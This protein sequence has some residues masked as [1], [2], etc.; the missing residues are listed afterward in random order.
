ME[1]P[2]SFATECPKC[3][4]VVSC[5]EIAS[6]RQYDPD[7]GPPERYVFS[8]CPK[9]GSPFLTMQLDF[10]QGYDDHYRIFPSNDKS[11][12]FGIPKLIR[13]SFDEALSCFKVKAYTAC[14]I[15]CRKTL[16]GI[17]HEHGVKS[18][19]LAKSLKEMKD[20]GI[21]ESRLFEWAEALRH[22]GNEAAHGVQT[23]PLKQDTQDILDFSYALIEYVFTFRDK[24][25]KF[26]ERRKKEPN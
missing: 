10:G 16:E 20:K 13:E 26:Q 23:K 21:I 15:M 1:K 19:N 17:C 6:Y 7:E 5:E 8:K 18:T 12:G 25:L 14:A 3:E 4:T 11:L 2:Q 24:F 22:F 9:C